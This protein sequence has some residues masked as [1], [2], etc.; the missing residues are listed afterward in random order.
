MF[1]RPSWSRLTIWWMILLPI[2]FF[3]CATNNSFIVRDPPEFDSRISHM[4][5][6]TVSINQRYEA[7]GVV[8]AS[9]ITLTAP[10]I[11]NNTSVEFSDMILMLPSATQVKG[12]SPP[13]MK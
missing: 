9:F 11:D 7:L 6:R 3:P 12:F 5:H 2:R 13:V 10:F 4:A 8:E 1:H